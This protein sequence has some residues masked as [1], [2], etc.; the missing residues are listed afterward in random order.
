MND[1]QRAWCRRH[2][3]TI[4][5]IDRLTSDELAIP[6]EVPGWQT[7]NKALY[8][9]RSRF[10]RTLWID[11]DAIVVNDLKPL[12]KILACHPLAVVHPQRVTYR[13]NREEL[14]QRHPVGTR[15]A[16]NMA[17]NAGVLGFAKHCGF[18]LLEQYCKMTDLARDQAVR[19]LITW[20][21][22]GIYHWA[23]QAAGLPWIIQ[24]NHGWN[25]FVFP[26]LARWTR[27]PETFL[28][29]LPILDID[30]IL[31]MTGPTKY[32]HRWGHFVDDENLE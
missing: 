6:A 30:V 14:Y 16:M 10:A 28:N 4:V 29:S 1:Q 24:H 15:L 17:V 13:H 11:A 5:A 26:D 22:E 12:F 32:W 8:I 2:E 31:H 3:D 20:Y 21:D 25:R 9:Q 19:E 18:G 23:L 27:T 7:W